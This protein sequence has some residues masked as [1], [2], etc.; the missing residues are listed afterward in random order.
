ME[1]PDKTEEAVVSI[2]I[3]VKQGQ[4]VHGRKA[5]SFQ[6][7]LQA[8]FNGEVL[9]ESEKK[10]GDPEGHP[11]DYN[12][13][14][15]LQL[16]N[17]ARTR[18]DVAQKP[19]MITVLELLPEEKKSKIN[20]V[21]LGQ[22]ALGLM[23]LLQGQSSF[24]SILSV[25]PVN[26]SSVRDSQLGFSHK[27]P[28]LDVCVSVADPLL[29]EDELSSSN[30]L[31]ITLDAVYSV[32][33]SW[34]PVPTPVTYAAALEVPLTAEQDQVVMFSE[35]QLK[36]GGDDDKK[37][38]MNHQSVSKSYLQHD[39]QLEQPEKDEEPTSKED[40]VFCHEAESTKS[41]VS[42]DSEICCFL[43]AGGASRLQQKI[44]ES[45][46]WPVEVMRSTSPLAKL[47]SDNSEI[48][49]HGVAYVDFGPL[50]YPGVSSIR[51]AYAIQAFSEAELLNQAKRSVSVLKEQAKAAANQARSR[52]NSAAGTQKRT[53]KNFD[54]N[55]IA[56]K[57]PKEPAKK[58]PS[59]SNRMAPND[60]ATSL[61]ENEPQLNVEANMYLEAKSFIVI[62]IALDKPLVAQISPEEVARR[63][64]ALIPP[65]PLPPEGPNRA[66]KAVLEFHK[67]V[68][69]A[70]DVIS[71]QYNELFG[72]SREL[73]QNE[74][75]EQMLKQLM[76]A[77]N[78]SGRYFSF[79]EKFKH[80]IVR[81][82]RDKLRQT[83]T[84]S[85]P[86][87]SQE[88]VSQL[89]VYLVDETRVALSK[90][91]CSDVVEDCPEEI[92]LHS[93]QLLHFAKEAQLTGN[94]QLAAQYYEEL[95]VRHTHEASYKFGW[96]SLFMLT[97][98]YIK[99]KECFYDAVATNQAHQPSLMMLGVLALMFER[100]TEA[101][102]F[103]ERAATTDPPSVPAWTLLGLFHE[104]QNE[105]ILAEWAFIEAKKLLRGD[106]AKSK[107]PKERE[108]D[109]EEQNKTETDQQG[110]K[111]AVPLQPATVEAAETLDL[112]DSEG[113]D[114]PPAQLDSKSAPRKLLSTIYTQT[115]QFLL[116]NNAPQMAEHALS[117]ELL[118]S[119][120]G[121]SLSYLVLLAKLQ[122][123]KG[124]YSSA[125][126][127]L[128]EAL[129]LTNEDAD[130]WALKGHCHYLQGAFTEAM[131]SYEWSLNIIKNPSDS[132][133]VL[134]RLGS[135]YL[136]EGKFQQAKVTYLQAC[137]QS[138]SCLT[139]LG[140]GTACYHLQELKEAEEALTEANHLNTEN[141]E[142]WA[143]LSLICLKSA[144]QQEAK[145][146][147]KYAV[148]FNLQND[149]LLE[150]IRQLMNQLHLSQ[151]DSCFGTN[152]KIDV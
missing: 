9:G 23:P 5:G 113:W 32:P 116:E 75:Q 99:A 103:L 81:I 147:Y 60:T 102:T 82:V 67:Q 145:L 77:L 120:G 49:F 148:R 73:P 152:I 101:Q 106:E 40:Q 42:W 16:P 7:F 128:K 79:H 38:L 17:D 68:G 94:Y 143:Y 104:S 126:D 69:D 93:S 127:S 43:D 83:D 137:E 76:G 13:T 56:A 3:S 24:S 37:K 108:K 66:E 96:G 44:I 18:S 4:N 52:A 53:G 1:T 57:D 97:K 11:V 118:C 135:I 35:G 112:Q 72:A 20:T 19:V 74:S 33:E 87:E 139:W 138:P 115:V 39:V 146:F 124:D 144:R 80:A 123:L 78:V 47:G 110:G 150:E 27:Q 41:R 90:I 141:A 2:N 61:A 55:Y 28:S 8:A 130:V 95:V 30:F 132:H 98:D 107:G 88:F 65:R 22:A 84:F 105:P 14:F 111:G 29:S 6:S 134:L 151:V 149:L 133:I 86:Q 129:L 51:G 131:E 31:K 21:A 58:Q 25:N 34:V 117:Q 91:Y 85:D 64:K 45:R 36:P 10:P 12:F 63:L 54:G 142:V 62:K 15:L 109:T 26:S 71:Q 140:L 89:Y 59:G 50:L 121:R 100:Y 114:E 70:V 46:L 122:L 119:E 136:L 125:A 92:S 48:P